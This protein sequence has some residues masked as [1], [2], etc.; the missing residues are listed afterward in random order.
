MLAAVAGPPFDADA[1]LPAGA[2]EGRESARPPEPREAAFRDVAAGDRLGRYE[3]VEAIGEGGMAQVFRARDPELRRD[4][5]IKVLFP[6]LSRRGEIVRRFQREARAAARLRH[7][8]ILQTYDVGGGEGGEPPYIVMEL[9]R[10]TSLQEHAAASGPL[11]SELAACAGVVI[12]EALAVAHEAGV[13]HRDLK[14]ANLLV[15][16][17]GRLLLAD[18]GVA[19]VERDEGEGASLATRTGAVLGTPA[20]MSPEQA[21][22]EEVDARSDLYSL[23]ATLYHLVTGAPPYAGSPM[24]VM[25]QLATPGA[26]VPPV[27]RR[28]AVG[29]ALSAAIVELMAHAAAARPASA[30][31]ADRKSTRLN[32]SHRYIS[33]MPSSA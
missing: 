27:K 32:S 16:E 31:A 21:S 12:A 23:G 1:T 3:L 22:G 20:Y 4:V 26:L 30:R 7:P 19:Y 33:R 5:A 24:K 11:L 28:P 29:R 25:S 17:D 18:F 9:V 15:S 2:G 13:I 14:P 10:G 6:H 8:A